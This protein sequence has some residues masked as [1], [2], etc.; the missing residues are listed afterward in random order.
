MFLNLN[1]NIAMSED[2]ELNATQAILFSY[3]CK[4]SQAKQH[5]II[6][7]NRDEIVNDLP[8]FFNTQ[9]NVYR[10]LVQLKKKSLITV[11]NEAGI[12]YIKITELGRK[13]DAY[14]K[15]K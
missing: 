5:R 1:I 15:I 10:N 9:D 7:I 8:S 14:E 11:E 13:W 12:A 3:L 2:Y 4:R 6:S